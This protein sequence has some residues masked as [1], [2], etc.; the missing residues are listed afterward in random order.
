[1]IDRR[2]NRRSLAIVG[3]GVCFD[4]GGLNV[5]GCTL[6]ASHEK[7]H[8][9]LGARAR[10]RPAVARAQASPLRLRLLLPVVE[11]A[12]SRDAMRPSDIYASRKGDTVEIGHTDAEGRLLLADALWEASAPCSHAADRDLLPAACPP[13]L[14]VDVATL[15][16]AARI[17]TGPLLP[18]MFAN[19]D[20]LAEQLLAC[21]FAV[22][23]PLWRF[24]LWQDYRHALRSRSADLC[25]S[26]SW[27]YAGSITA[28]LF[29]QN[30]VAPT[31][32]WI[33]LDVMAWNERM[34]AGRLRAASCKA[35]VR[36]PRSWT[37]GAVRRETDP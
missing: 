34:R 37:L 3:K 4:S 18:N 14:V 27:P 1:M 31:M 12:V 11:N 6:D 36:S 26:G 35:C 21:A 24:P 28:A 9:R 8:G 15:T 22:Q 29:L 23:D 7:R 10:A 13:D 32:L 16:G 19:D 30:F 2:I 5:E 33:H 17:A 25:S 20:T